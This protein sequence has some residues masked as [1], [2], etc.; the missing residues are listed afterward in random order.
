MSKFTEF[1]SKNNNK[2]IEV[3]DP[4]NPFQCFDLVVA[5]TDYLG[6]PR[7][8]PFTFAYQI[9]TSFGEAQAKYFD[10]IYNSADALVREGDI[11][12][13]SYSYN[14]GAGHTAIATG[15]GDLYNFKAFEQNDPEA[16]WASR[17]SHVRNYKYDYVL[18]R[19]RPKN[20]N[21]PVTDTQRIQQ[22]KNIINT[23]ISDSD[24]RN[25]TRS[26]LGV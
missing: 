14:R 7:V 15:E 17:N 26:I 20:L 12:V 19:L 9:Y 21:M 11:A 3:V 5:W 16:W 13:W 24:F 23:N 1:L 25:K 18:G 2:F 22:I 10:R 6:I 4:S 8:F